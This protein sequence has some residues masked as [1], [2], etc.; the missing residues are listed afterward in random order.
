MPSLAAR[1][2]EPSDAAE[3]SKGRFGNAVKSQNSLKHG[4]QQVRP[5]A[6]EAPYALPHIRDARQ[7]RRSQRR[8]EAPDRDFE[9]AQPTIPRSSPR[10]GTRDKQDGGGQRDRGARGA[11]N[12]MQNI[13]A[14]PNDYHFNS[15]VYGNNDRED[16]GYQDAK[17]P[18]ASA[19][20]GGRLP[21]SEVDDARPYVPN[22]D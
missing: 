15:Q 20:R 21:T 18:T 8:K 1:R 5:E 22:R 11:G 7:A 13:G 3:H 12:R 14:A 4:N 9:P 16:I 10:T 17:M 19:I 2:R 6:T